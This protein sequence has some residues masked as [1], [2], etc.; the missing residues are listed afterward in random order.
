MLEET[1]HSRL[2]VVLRVPVLYGH[3][4]EAKESAVNTLMDSLWKAQEKGAQI[5]MDDWSIRYPTNTEDVGRVCQDI[6][7][8]YLEATAEQQ[9]KMTTLLPRILQFS[10]E[11]RFTKYEMCEVF[12]EIMGLGMGGLVANKQGN[13]P[14]ASV[15]RPYD[16]HL[17]TTELKMLGI[18]VGTMDFKA[19]WL[20][21]VRGCC[22]LSGVANIS[23]G[24]ERQG[25]I[26]SKV[27]AT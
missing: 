14:K 24:E 3:A 13:D 21:A 26:G 11:D 10:S 6:A 15:Q 23:A 25:R 1:E 18:D 16:C 4:T 7:V 27:T 20:V 5:G 2:G 8:K 17:A 12:A 19:W 22:T 9:R